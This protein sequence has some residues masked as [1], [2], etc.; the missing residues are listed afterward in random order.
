MTILAKKSIIK[1]VNLKL[2]RISLLNFNRPDTVV[3]EFY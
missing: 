3:V 1:F 2:H